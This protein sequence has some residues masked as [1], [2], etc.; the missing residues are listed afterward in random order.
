MKTKTN[1]KTTKTTKAATPKAFTP[2]DGAALLAELFTQ[3]QAHNFPMTALAG[4]FGAAI[5]T[6]GD[7][8]IIAEELRKANTPTTEPEP[9]TPQRERHLPMTYLLTIKDNVAMGLGA[10]L[11][12]YAPP[13]IHRLNYILGL[14]WE[15]T[16]DGWIFEQDPE[17]LHRAVIEALQILGEL[18]EWNSDGTFEAYTPKDKGGK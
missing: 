18:G 11:K 2:D 17:G 7:K 16:T 1:R 13:K 8:D 9:T 5:A 15:H 6:D 14:L 10:W 3:W 4:G 12:Q